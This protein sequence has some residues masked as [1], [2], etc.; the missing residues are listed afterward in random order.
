MDIQSICLRGDDFKAN[1]CSNNGSIFYTDY[2]SWRNDSWKFAH[3]RY[4]PMTIFNQTVDGLP[5]HQWLY[6]IQRIRALNRTFLYLN[7][8]PNGQ[9]PCQIEGTTQELCAYCL[10]KHCNSNQLDRPWR[11]LHKT[12][13]DSGCLR[14]PRTAVRSAI[15]GA[16][17]D[18]A[19]A[20]WSNKKKMQREPVWTCASFEKYRTPFHG[21]AH[22]FCSLGRS[23]QARSEHSWT[24]TACCSWY[25]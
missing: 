13:W 21:N 16:S 17:F 6:Y 20:N 15:S 19:P 8:C 12:S 7:I 5:W 25:D 10:Y 4:V 14:S 2:Y 1:F 18:P 9:L 24:T 11:Q 22:K 23:D 3:M